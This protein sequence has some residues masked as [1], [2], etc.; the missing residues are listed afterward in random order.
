MIGQVLP[1]ASVNL[2]CEVKNEGESISTFWMRHGSF[3]G[4]GEHLLG[5]NP[6]KA[7]PLRDR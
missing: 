7:V 6:I 4:S 2:S 3:V 1:T 5:E